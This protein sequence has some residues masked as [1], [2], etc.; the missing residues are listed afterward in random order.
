MY[1]ISSSSTKEDYI[2]LGKTNKNQAR[3]RHSSGDSVYIGLGEDEGQGIYIPYI[4]LSP[5]LVP[6]S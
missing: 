5:I 2:L 3:Q 6:A 1:I 4:L